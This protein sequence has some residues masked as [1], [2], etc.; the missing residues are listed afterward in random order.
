MDDFNREAL[1]IELDYSIKSNKVV[2]ILNHLI[3]RRG[4]PDII[5][6]DNGPKF[7]ATL[8]EEWSQ[9]KGIKLLQYVFTETQF[10]IMV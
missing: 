2:Y 6:M 10:L 9:I 7:I 4:K 3:K 1:H 5:R 8:L